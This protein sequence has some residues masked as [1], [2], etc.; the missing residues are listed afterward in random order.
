ML[1]SNTNFSDKGKF[2]VRF[3]CYWWMFAFVLDLDTRYQA[4]WLAGLVT[5]CSVEWDTI[6]HSIIS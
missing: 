6:V 1:E 4:K 2:V 5:C 3:L